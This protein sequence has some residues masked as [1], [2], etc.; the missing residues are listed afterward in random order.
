[1]EFAR[2]FSE[3]SPTFLGIVVGSMFT[4]I[5]VIL[6]NTSNTKR[7]RLQHEHEQAL[8]SKERD[9]SLRRETY[10]GAIE[11]ISA[12]MVAV[13]R[14]GE[15]N[16]SPQEL[17][18]AYTNKSPAIAKVMVVGQNDTVKAVANFNSELTGTFIRLTSKRQ[19]V[20]NILERN[21]AI[22]QEIE[23]SAKELSRLQALMEDNLLHGKPGV[24]QNESLLLKFSA[25]KEKNDLLANEQNEL[26]DKLIPTQMNLVMECMEEITRLDQMLTPVIG[27]MRAEL[28]LPF[29]EE[30]YNQIIEENHRKQR[31]FLQA[32][33]QDWDFETSEKNG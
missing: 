4:I 29:D 14:F 6:T 22:G 20:Q 25:E 15:F 12:G 27:L 21:A 28:E 11:A 1:M 24:T 17:M 5:G 13:G 9:A 32:F 31:S 33:M 19:N 26:L 3:V 23:E 2:Y 18:E 10:L 7:L 16:F 8:E 30:K